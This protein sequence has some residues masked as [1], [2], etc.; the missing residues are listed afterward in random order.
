MTISNRLS[1][2]NRSYKYLWLG[3]SILFC[4]Y[5]GI[6]F[7][8]YVFSHD[9]IVQDDARQ[10]IV[11]L[12]RFSDPE[13][14]PQDIIANY[15]SGLAPLGFK[16]LY[17]LA[18]QV[19]IEPILLAKLLPPILALITTIYIYLFTLEILPIPIT[20]FFSSLLLNQLIWLN[21]DLVSATARAF[22][23][24]L[25]AAFL[26]Y[27]AKNKIIP[28]LILMFLQGLFYPHL[29]LIEMA[30]LS[31]RLL[32]PKN[33]FSIKLTQKKQPY[34]W[35]ICGLIVTAIALYP[36]TQKP[37]ELAIVVTAEQMQQMP[38]FNLGGRSE[39]Y[40]GGWFKYW[41]TGSSGL[42]LPLFPTIVWF[43]V[44]LP[45]LLTTKLQ[46]IKLIT[47]KVAI[48]KQLT[49]ASLF[50]FI[51]AQLLLPRLH[52]PNRYTY[53][54]SR[55]ILAI[56]TGIVLTILLDLGWNW[57]E[58]KK[59]FNQAA[60]IKLALV[61]LFSLIVIIFPAIPH[62][63]TN[64][65][66][67]WRI[68]TVPEIYQYLARQPKDILVASLSEEVNNLPAFSRR[69]ILAGSEFSL[70]YHPMYY[71]QIQQ[72]TIDLLQAQYTP[73]LKV[74][75]SFI[76]QYKIDF[77]LI[78]TNAFTSEYLLTKSWLIN[79][80][81]ADETQKVVEILRSGSSPKLAELVP[82]CSVVSTENLN[83]LDATCI[84]KIK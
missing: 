32:A 44:A 72:R 80:Y 60:K 69:S 16:S 14:F 34:I 75:Q 49:I 58:Q 17:F 56:A 78:E 30:I 29:L 71:N 38:E 36:I 6:Y 2:I 9:Y 19:G 24:P 25:L 84:E 82:A 62:V 13:L 1:T 63:F 51:L 31:L 43:G 5:Y 65:F 52:L 79:S 55:F 57:L 23:Y 41:F 54:S 35:W 26:Y 33:N 67:N 8:Y 77:I 4:L 73:E 27:L 22:L 47:D 70:A 40:G 11:W 18:A 7:Y 74:L 48:L 20:A 28:C 59:Q 15:F 3:I 61:T 21:D 64:W 37:P 42:S 10:H 66:Q 12:Q 50:L 76:E 45:F 39:F 53:H 46:I 68:G 83:L 81:Y